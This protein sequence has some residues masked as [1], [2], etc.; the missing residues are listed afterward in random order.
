MGSASSAHANSEPRIAG[1]AALPRTVYAGLYD[2]PSKQ[3]VSLLW[4]PLCEQARRGAGWKRG[5]GRA[6]GQLSL[7]GPLPINLLN[8]L[9]LPRQ[10]M[11]RGVGAMF[12]VGSTRELSEATLRAYQ[13]QRDLVF[14]GEIELL[15]RGMMTPE[16][17]IAAMTLHGVL[18][19][20]MGMVVGLF[21]GTYEAIAPPIPLPG[22]P[23]PP[24]RTMMQE[25]RHGW[26]RSGVK[27][28]SWG[29]NFA[30]VTLLW[31]GFECTVEKLRG[32]HDVYNAALAGCA[33]GAAMAAGQGPEAMC[34]GCVHAACPRR[35]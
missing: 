35:V 3:V 21:L 5:A 1:A 4:R 32:S 19:G 15:K 30:G 18:G 13:Q 8:T 2:T 17:C 28:R 23:E 31:S 20:V 7:S 14:D 29:K 33:T 12:A 10:T 11:L 9:A 16:P 27:A 22:Q 24:K 34:F 6:V 25:V 26:M